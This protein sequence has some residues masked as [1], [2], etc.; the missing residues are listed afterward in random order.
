MASISTSATARRAGLGPTVS[1]TGTSANPTLAR[2]EQHVWTGSEH[3]PANVQMDTK[4]IIMSVL[5]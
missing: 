3:T 4:V 5:M 1:Q 2:M